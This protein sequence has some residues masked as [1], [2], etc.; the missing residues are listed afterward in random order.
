MPEAIATGI[1]NSEV[2]LR[3]GRGRDSWTVKNTVSKTEMVR[4]VKMVRVLLTVRTRKKKFQ[5]LLSSFE[6]EGGRNILLI[7]AM[8]GKH[9]V[10]S[11]QIC[12]CRSNDNIKVCTVSA[13]STWI[14]FQR[15]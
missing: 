1:S 14:F 6:F 13:E 10:D 15:F 9:S 3:T 4:M 7:R 5:C 2:R 12:F 8:R 11:G